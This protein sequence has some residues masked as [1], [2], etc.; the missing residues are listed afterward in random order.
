M[1]AGRIFSSTQVAA[2]GLS[3]ERKRMEVVS[4][5]IANAHSTRTE[6]GTAFRRR[7]VV[8][9]AVN[10]NGRA[11][12]EFG[13][14]QVLAVEEDL[15]EL[16]RVYSPGHPDADD[17]GMLTMPNVSIPTEMV[18][19]MTASRAYEANLR[20]LSTFRDMAEQTLTLLRAG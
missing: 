17:Q 10:G 12:D 7:D 16:P 14:V 1:S 6:S 8:F 20:V 11:A 3:A 18:D 13:G 9:A 19:L 2:S 4:N 5:N 15:S